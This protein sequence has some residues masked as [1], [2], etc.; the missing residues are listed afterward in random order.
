MTYHKLDKMARMHARKR[1]KARSNKP[2][3]KKKPVWLSYSPKEVEQLVIKLAKGGKRPPE[4]GLILRDSYG[5]PD[6][7]LVAKKKIVSILSENNLK[8]KLPSD[9]QDLIKKHISIMK[10]MAVNKKDITGKFRLGLVGSKI[11]RLEKYYKKKGVLPEGWFYDKTK[12][13]L[14]TE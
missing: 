2:L 11:R 1:G 6:V 12:A 10:H 3:I 8:P 7:K 14:L 5:I 4:I 13:K 9:F